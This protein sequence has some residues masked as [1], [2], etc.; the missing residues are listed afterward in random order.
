MNKTFKVI[1]SKTRNCYV[2]VSELAKKHSKSSKSGIISKTLMTAVLLSIMSGSVMASGVDTGIVTS[3]DGYAGGTVPIVTGNGSIAIGTHAVASGNNMTWEQLKAMMDQYNIKKEN[4]DDLSTTVAGDVSDVNNAQNAFNAASTAAVAVQAARDAQ[5]GYQSDLDNHNQQKPAI[6]DAYNTAKDEYETLY[7]DFQNRLSY[8]RTI[9]FSLADVNT[10]AGLTA[11]ATDLKQNTESGTPFNYDLQFYKDYI[12]NYIKY[13]GDLRLNLYASSTYSWYKNETGSASGVGGN[14][15]L[16]YKRGIAGIASGTASSAVCNFLNRLNPELNMGEGRIRPALLSF[17]ESDGFYISNNNSDMN[18]NFLSG[19]KGGITVNDFLAYADSYVLDDSKYNDS[20]N[21]IDNFK[22][23][24]LNRA[25]ALVDGF[26]S[27]GLITAAQKTEFLNSLENDLNRNVSAAKALC[28]AMHEQYLYEQDRNPS[29]LTV[30]QQQLIIVENNYT[31]RSK[32]FAIGDG[33]LDDAIAQW[34][35]DNIQSVS[36]STRVTLQSLSD[37]FNDLLAQ[38]K[39]AYDDATAAK[40]ANDNAIT[41]LQ[42]QIA[43]LEPTPEQ[44]ALADELDQKAQDLQNAQDKLAADEAALQQAYQDMLNAQVGEIGEGAIAIGDS[45]ITTGKNAIGVGSNVIVTGEEAVAFGSGTV[46]SGKQAVG[47]G[48]NNSISKDNAIAIGTNNG[49]TGQNSIAIGNDNVVSGENSIAIGNSLSVSENNVVALGGKKVSGVTDGAVATDA[50][51]VGQT[52]ELVAGRGVTIEEDGVNAIGQK[53][54]KLNSTATGGA[55]YNAGSHI[56]IEDGTIDSKN[57]IAY[58]SDVNDVATMSGTRGTKLTNLKAATIESGSTDAVIGHQLWQTNKNIEGFAQDINRNKTNITTLN[59]SVTDALS[60]VAAISDLVDTMDQLKADSSLNNLTTQGR[61]IINTAA[62]DAVQAYMA[63]HSG[64]TGTPNRKS[65]ILRGPNDAPSSETN[66]HGVGIANL[67][68]NSTN[69][70]GGGAIGYDSVAIG[71]SKAAGAGSVAVGSRAL[72]TGTNSVAIGTNATATGD[73]TTREEIETI[74]ANNKAIRDTLNDARADYTAS[75]ADYDRQ[76]EIWEGQNE[77]YARV[78]A[79][80]QT[81]AGYQNEINSTLQPNAD[82]A[83][84][85]YNTAKAD[86]DALYNDFR[87]RIEH[88][89]TID[90][91]LYTNTSTGEIDKDAM[92]VQLKSDTETGTVFDMP[93]S[94]YREYIDNYIKATGDL[95]LARISA[96]IVNYNENSHI[97]SVPDS[98]YSTSILESFLNSVNGLEDYDYLKSYAR[99]VDIRTGQVAIPPANTH[100]YSVNSIQSMFGGSIFP[101]SSSYKLNQIVQ[102]KAFNDSDF[103]QHNNSLDTVYNSVIDAINYNVNGMRLSGV[104]DEDFLQDYQRYY[105]ELYTREY[106]AAK[107]AFLVAHEQY[108][109]E[110][111]SDESEKLVHLGLK[112]H[113]LNEYNDILNNPVAGRSRSLNDVVSNWCY[114]HVTV[115]ADAVNVTLHAVEEGLEGLLAEKQ[116]A[117]ADATAAKNAADQALA[118]KQQQIADATPSQQDL[119]DAAAAEASA[120][121]LAQKEAKLESDREALEQAKANLQNLETIATDGESAIAIGGNAV[122]TAENGIGIGTDALVTGEEAIGIGKNAIASGKNSIAIGTDNSVAKDNAIAVG[123]NNG[124]TGQNSIAIGNNN[125]VSG[126]NSVAIGNNLS[127]TEDNIVLIGSRRMTGVADGTNATDAATVGQ[128][129]ELVAGSGVTIQEDGVNAIGQKK[130]KLNSTGGGG[131]VYTSGDNIVIEDDVISAQGLIKYDGNDKSSASLEGTRGTKL[132]NLKA[133]NLSQTSSDAVIGNQLW[134]TNKNI[135]GFAQDINRNKTNITTLNQSVTDAL[136]SVS[137]I[138]DL[139]DAIDSLKADA[140]LNNLSNQGKA[141][142]ATAAANAVQAYMAEHGGSTGDTQNGMMYRSLGVVNPGDSANHV[143]YDD[144]SASSVTL[145]GSDGTI[146]H[147]VAAGTEDTDAVNVGQLSDYATKP[148]VNGIKEEL[149]ERISATEDL[150]AGDWEGKTVKEHIDSKLDESTF[151]SYKEST[152]STLSTM[153]DAIQELDDTKAD[154]DSVYTKEESDAMLADK[155]DADKVYTK[156]E[157]DTKLADKADKA[158]LDNKADKD[159][160]NIDVQTWADKLGIGEVSEGNEGLVKGGEVF[161]AIKDLGGNNMV[162]SDGQTIT[163]GANDSASRIDISNADG[164]SRVIT[165]VAVDINDPTSAANVGYVNALNEQANQAINTGISRLDDK[166]NKTGAGAAALANLHPMDT[167][168][169]TRWNISA[170]VGKY[171]GST[172]G[173]LGVFYKP[174]ERVMMNLSSTIGNNDTMFGAGVTVAVDK[175]M[176]NGMSKVQLVKTVNAQAEKLQQQDAINEALIA[177]IKQLKAEMAEMKSAK[178]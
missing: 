42:N 53:K 103:N 99:Y 4:H 18:F 80:N 148:E 8:I 108:L 47:I 114:E 146:I 76:R 15:D 74:L 158:D 27:C 16:Y 26:V 79:A 10:D 140:S 29:H 86:Y 119:D 109:Y 1:W 67:S 13:V 175:P 75:Q 155:A 170:A 154:K 133:G 126:Q 157:T 95:R 56:T 178:K 127:V 31:T 105:T 19:V 88:I 98:S 64:S 156:E 5:A 163:I 134:Q 120:Q 9:D 106:N 70:N 110:T 3:S 131:A 169:D 43:S 71:D 21:A 66:I 90:F 28:M 167:D 72:T 161:N 82:S 122:T 33:I 65:A 104:F 25:T 172:A 150:L 92:A 32:M 52:Y 142:I 138:S 107:K 160:G 35:Y 94:F 59:Q 143:V 44:Q 97:A 124:I 129:Y 77:A 36:D 50:A 141:V 7:N 30:K 125:V 40:E 61:A 55:N 89:K 159:A 117:L 57:L 112:E 60:A 69:Y 11:L 34:G 49:I 38:K 121:D 168:G 48:S 14:P 176:A 123:T 37:N 116:Q 144:D 118:N 177:E 137:A 24:N 102:E 45:A 174:S 139:V 164:N 93:V 151:D 17:R 54:Y 153:N 96:A 78:Q 115:P 62:A 81:I 84:N 39:Q 173:A 152:A 132:T 149:A 20:L 2:V 68:E 130:F 100:T 135:E 166:I 46:V 145:E 6:D 87:S 12:T 85:A 41:N 101:T 128:T 162:Q 22:T 91:S 165:G 113:Y 51:T 73:G 23:D 171:H 111:L 147:N 63:E 58:D 83:N 136:S